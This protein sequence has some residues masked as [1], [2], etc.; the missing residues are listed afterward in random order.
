M[1]TEKRHRFARGRRLYKQKQAHKL[2][3]YIVHLYNQKLTHQ[4]LIYG[5][6]TVLIHFLNVYGTVRR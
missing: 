5:G 1:T 6:I 2:G 4:L 3:C